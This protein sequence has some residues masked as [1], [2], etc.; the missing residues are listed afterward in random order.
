MKTQCVS[1]ALQIKEG[2]KPQHLRS[3]VPSKQVHN[4]TDQRAQ[5][6]N[7]RREGANAESNGALRR[8]S[9][10]G[11]AVYLAPNNKNEPQPGCNLRPPVRCEYPQ[12]GYHNNEL[13]ECILVYPESALEIRMSRCRRGIDAVHPSLLA[14]F[15]SEIESLHERKCCNDCNVFHDYSP[16]WCVVA[17]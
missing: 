16:Y 17:V 9:P 5:H 15:D 10:V 12:T 6:Q 8:V 14:Y 11:A 7:G 2:G 4:R 1:L 3:T 13:L